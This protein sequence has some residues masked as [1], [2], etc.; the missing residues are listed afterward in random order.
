MYKYIV[1]TLIPVI[2]NYSCFSCLHII[3]YLMITAITDRIREFYDAVNK[4]DV[5]WYTHF[6]IEHACYVPPG[7]PVTCISE[8]YTLIIIIKI[9]REGFLRKNI[10][11][12]SFFQ[13]CAIH[14]YS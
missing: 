3:Q 12:V 1:M 8:C 13:N 4:N 7:H 6:F 9:T 5:H 11:A 10:V 14:Q 2:Y